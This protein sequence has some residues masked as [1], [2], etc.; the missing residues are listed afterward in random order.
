MFKM[1]VM[2]VGRIICF[3]IENIDNEKYEEL[4]SLA[5]ME[6]VERAERYRMKE[7][8][9]RCIVSDLLLKYALSQHS[10]KLEKLP[11]NLKLGKNKHGKPFVE[12]TGDFEFNISHSGKWVVLGCGKTPLG[13]DVEKIR[14]DE[15]IKKISKRYFT[16]KENE[17]VL[18]KEELFPERFA[19]IWTGKESYLKYLGVGIGGLIKTVDVLPLK[20]KGLLGKR[21]DGEYYLS[22][23]TE[24]QIEIITVGYEELLSVLSK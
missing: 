18:E 22:Y 7:D 3:N 9:V 24:E 8:K 17:Y 23:F 4:C 10:N 20:E 2:S 1:G 21:F 13:V 5:S 15:E 6:R 19:E 12:E 14:S 11:Q 16:Q